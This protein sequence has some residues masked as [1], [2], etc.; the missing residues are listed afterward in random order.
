VRSVVWGITYDK[1]KLPKL[2]DWPQLIVV[3]VKG[4]TK[5]TADQLVDEAGGHVTP[6]NLYEAQKQKK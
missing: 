3:G 6:A 1:G 2:P 5:G 4:Y